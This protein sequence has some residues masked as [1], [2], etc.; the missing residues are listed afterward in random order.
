MT[1]PE[2]FVQTEVQ[3]VWEV[4]REDGTVW[5]SNEEPTPEAA[6]AK[7][8]GDQAKWV[9]FQEKFTEKFRDADTD[10]PDYRSIRLVAVRQRTSVTV[11][12]Y[13]T[14][15]GDEIKFPEGGES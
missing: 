7:A 4:L 9:G 2:P 1:A 6:I 14:E 12:V 8:R 10:M 11:N 13:T 5:T 15:Y 3:R